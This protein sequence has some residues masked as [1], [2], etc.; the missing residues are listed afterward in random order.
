MSCWILQSIKPGEKFSETS[1]HLFFVI[2]KSCQ[3]ARQVYDRAVERLSYRNA[4]MDM[5]VTYTKQTA[6]NARS[7]SKRIP[8]CRVAR[9]PR[10][11][12]SLPW[13]SHD[14]YLVSASL[15]LFRLP[16]Q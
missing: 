9:R 2:S 16:N 7:G 11:S 5:L 1:V 12:P 14:C 6:K 15:S 8:N 10:Y 3:I 13:C 4:D